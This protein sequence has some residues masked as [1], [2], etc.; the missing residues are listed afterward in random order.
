MSLILIEKSVNVVVHI[1]QGGMSRAVK[2]GLLFIGE[3]NKGQ[4]LP[5]LRSCGVRGVLLGTCAR[6]WLFYFMHKYQ[7]GR[8][9]IKSSFPVIIFNSSNVHQFA[10]GAPAGLFYGAYGADYPCQTG[11]GRFAGRGAGS[12]AGYVGEIC[13]KREDAL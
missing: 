4:S 12:L 2:R 3:N 11:L 10:P 9:A 6:D 7:G 8:Y 13:R 5:D 1:Y